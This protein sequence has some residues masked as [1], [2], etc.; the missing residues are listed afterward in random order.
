M[1]CNLECGVKIIMFCEF[2]GKNGH[3]LSPVLKNVKCHKISEYGDR[4]KSGGNNSW[5]N[6]RNLE[7]LNIDSYMVC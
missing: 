5:Y 7:F 2:G 6:Q 1:L 3:G 4:A